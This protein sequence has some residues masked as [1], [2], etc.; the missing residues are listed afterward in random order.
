MY[1]AAAAG[2]I[3]A[4]IVLLLIEVAISRVRIAETFGG[5]LFAVAFFAIT[6]VAVA[7]GTAVMASY[8]AKSLLLVAVFYLVSFDGVD[9]KI[10]AVSICTS[11]LVYL[12]VQTVHVAGRGRRLQRRIARAGKSIP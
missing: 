1:Y 11:S 2:L 7:F 5:A 10:A 8:I 12:T 9:E 3:A 6:S 4:P